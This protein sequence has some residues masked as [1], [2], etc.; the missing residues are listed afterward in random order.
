M[1]VIFTQNLSHNTA[2]FLCGRVI[3]V[4]QFIHREQY[5]AVNRLEPIAHIGQCATYYYRHRI[6]DVGG[7]HLLVDIYGNYAVFDRSFPVV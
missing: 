5:A 6:I 3:I 1:W 7:L 2:D 4:A